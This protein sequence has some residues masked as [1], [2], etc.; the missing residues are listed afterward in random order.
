MSF[1]GPRYDEDAYRLAL[2][3]ST[4]P[5]DYVLAATAT[6]QR[7]CQMADQVDAETRLSLRAVPLSH[8]PARKNAPLPADAPNECPVPKQTWDPA[9]A[10][11]HHPRAH[12]KLANPPGTLR[13]QGV[14]R[15]HDP[16]FDPQAPAAAAAAARAWLPVSDRSHA[17]DNFVAGQVS[18]VDA[19]NAL[20]PPPPPLAP[21]T[22]TF[23]PTPSMP[24]YIPMARD[25]LLKRMA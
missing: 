4:A 18:P 15:W 14:N 7:A 24:V 17:R 12:C 1:S 2:A 19:R 8:C 9:H 21:E 10:P 11:A 5:A 22:F 13:G 20:P 6:N 25:E 16:G 23:D 3:E